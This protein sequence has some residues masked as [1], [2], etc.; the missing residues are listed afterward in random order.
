MRQSSPTAQPGP[1]HEE[2]DENP[3]MSAVEPEIVRVFI[4]QENLGWGV[5]R[6]QPLPRGHNRIA[7]TQQSANVRASVF[8]LAE[9]PPPCSRITVLLNVKELAALG[10]EATGYA[11]VAG[12]DVD[13]LK[14]GIVSLER[15]QQPLQHMPWAA[16]YDQ[17]ARGRRVP[18]CE[19]VTHY[20]YCGPG[21][22]SLDGLCEA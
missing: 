1:Q 17:Y 15:R 8:Q 7:G 3:P 2:A 16:F 14:T 10:V 20:F 4:D 21:Q 13:L 11:R 5:P 22:R 19:S 6:R 12:Q 18:A 9:K